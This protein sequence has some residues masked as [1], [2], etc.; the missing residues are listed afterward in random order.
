MLDGI[1]S[2]F[3][4]LFNCRIVTYCNTYKYL[5][6]TL[7]EFLN[8]NKTSETQSE[9]AGRALGALI[10][11]TIKNGGFPY[12]IY[13]MLYEC[14][15]CSV[16]DYGSEIWGFECRDAATKIQLRATRVFLGLPKTATSAGVLAE[17]SC[18][19]GLS[20]TD[21]FVKAILSNPEDGPVKANK[22]D[23]G[24]GRQVF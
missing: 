11:K 4:F 16:S 18:R 14:L 1:Q 19:T 3:V 7:D 9:S 6:S 21:P 22:T 8:F 17:M 24:V 12:S 5:G 13:T 2:K 23:S 10:T 20:H 15:V